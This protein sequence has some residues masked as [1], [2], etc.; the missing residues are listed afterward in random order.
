MVS[1]QAGIAPEKRY[2]YRVVLGSR[3]VEEFRFS[4]PFE[5]S[6][7]ILEISCDKGSLAYKVKTK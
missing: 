2:P 7:L 3:K 5:E 1:P 4:V 6:D